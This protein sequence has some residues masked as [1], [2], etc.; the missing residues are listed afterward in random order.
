MGGGEHA[1]ID[2]PQLQAPVGV[3]S[4]LDAKDVD[5]HN[6]VMDRVKDSKIAIPYTI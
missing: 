5:Q 2:M 6:V 1:E 4:M 3:F